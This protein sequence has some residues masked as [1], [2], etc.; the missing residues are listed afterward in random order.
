MPYHI[1]VDSLAAMYLN[2]DKMSNDQGCTKIL[3]G[4]LEAEMHDSSFDES[5]HRVVH[6]ERVPTPEG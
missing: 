1:E 5:Q 6:P 4:Q 2:D 3:G